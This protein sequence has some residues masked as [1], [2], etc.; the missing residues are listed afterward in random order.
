MNNKTIRNIITVIWGMMF[1]VHLTICLWISNPTP[2]QW[3]IVGVSLG[4]VIILLLDNRSINAQDKL[5]KLY[6]DSQ[7]LK[8]ILEKNKK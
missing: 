3:I 7:D 6:R 4:G 5:I 1:C 2:I 8:K